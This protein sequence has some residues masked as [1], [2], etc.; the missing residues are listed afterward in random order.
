MKNLAGKVVFITGGASGIGL[1]LARACGEQG[2]RVMLADIDREALDSAVVQLSNEQIDVDGVICDVTSEQSL[3]DAADAA[4]ERFGKIHMLVN[5][6]GVLVVGGVGENALDTWRWAMDVNVMGVIYGT[7]IFLPLIREHGEG[8][9]ILNTASVGGHVAYGGVLAYSTTKH[10][11]VGYTEALADQL[12]DEGIGV[13]ALCPGFTNTRIAET[14][15][16]AGNQEAE[17]GKD[18]GFVDAVEAGMSPQV[19]A[20][21]TLEQIQ[22]DA[23]YIFTHPGTRGEV[24]ERWSVI[25]SAFDATDASEVI[26]SDPDAQRIARKDEVDS[27]YH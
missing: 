12:K 20:T 10:A 9:H 17:A 2:M 16:F 1:A 26:N 7:E 24:A 19:V 5:N 25:S 15:R 6:A 14:E 4:I 8:G 22:Q 13:S 21:F 11:V 18:S 27:L 3:R 23:L